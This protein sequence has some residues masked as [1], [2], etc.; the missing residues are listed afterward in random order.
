MYHLLRRCKRYTKPNRRAK[1][2]N[3][4][5]PKSSNRASPRPLAPPQEQ[6]SHLEDRP[7]L[8]LQHHRYRI[9]RN[10]LAPSTLHLVRQLPHEKVRPEEQEIHAEDQ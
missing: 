2:S 8:A 6:P 7:L 4:P 1:H 10:F 3:L 9:L 5:V